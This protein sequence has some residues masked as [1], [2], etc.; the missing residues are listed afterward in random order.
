MMK[1]CLK[2][3]LSIFLAITALILSAIATFFIMTADVK[4]NPDKLLE[5]G[6]TI[7]VFDGDG[8]KIESSGYYS[9]NSS[10]NLSELNRQ[11]IR[12]FIA[13]EDK[14]FYTH[15]GINI[16]RMIKA[17]Y[18]NITAKAFKEGASTISQQ[19]IK[20]THLNN[21][22]TI[23]RKLKEIRLSLQLEKNYSKDEILEMYLNT[24]Y[25]GHNCYGLE[26]AA[27]FYYGIPAT[28]LNLEQ[29]ATIAGLLSSP[30]NYS[31]FKNPEACVKRRNIVLKAMQNC[32]F[33][34][35]STYV[36]TIKLPLSTKESDNYEYN[37]DYLTAVF[38]ELESCN[39]EPYGNFNE[40]KIETYCNADLQKACGELSSEYDD[41]II[42]RKKD[43]KV[44]AYRSDI[45]DAKRQIGSTAKPIF[46]YA[47]A[48]EEK[49]IGLFTKIKDEAV[50]YGGYK[51]ENYDKKYHGNVSVEESI[52][53]SYN[54]P[55]VKTLNALGVK[56]A[57]EYAKKLG[58]ELNESD[59]NLSLAL[60]GINS[61]MS[62]KRLCDSYAVFQNQGEFVESKFIKRITDNQG[63]TLYEN[64][65]K[66]AKTFSPS[67]CSLINEA[68]IN[69]AKIGTG[70]KLKNFDFDV[71]C[72][73]GT[74][75][76]TEGNTDA[77]ALAYTSDICVGVW[78]GDR[79]NAKTEVTGGGYC[80]TITE[81]IL[82][83]IYKSEKPLPLDTKTGTQE[84]EVDREE[85][86]NNDK[87]I[88]C[89][90]HCPKLNR[91]KL[92]CAS[93]NLPIERSTRFTSPTIPKPTITV[94]TNN[95]TIGLCQ[96]KYYSYLIKRRNNGNTDTIYNGIWK[97]EIY[98]VVEPGEY[99]YLITPYYSDE[100]NNFYGAEISLPKIFISAD[101]GGADI[102]DIAKK[103]WYNQ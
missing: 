85:Y 66:T 11:T 21:D 44:L 31:P 92:K 102:P 75:G 59:M 53:K 89:D 62:L 97:G 77:Y 60:G 68:L 69:T 61:G 100:G 83:K 32:N 27:Q 30:N 81:E 52:V 15:N 78:A 3:T 12:A 96:A 35:E 33:I 25:F 98:D 50:D 71:A 9:H 28:E 38:N 51:P 93:D 2:I 70:K 90:E 1:T 55:A 41:A 22:K 18:K 79:N 20:N 45:G 17:L 48:L 29:S 4:L 99:E 46:V 13:S 88:L 74:C 43:G 82:K 67:T 40:L 57:A 56:K 19:L 16:K 76:T 36:N 80:C 65:R 26:N 37:S 49:K 73:T 7:T 87:I 6:K 63:K 5:Q 8:N 54:I 23:S 58:V 14:Q 34:D 94:N 95:I 47:P 64:E 103:D 101:V 91:L 86:E 39:I 10:V 72:K 84:I 24:I 42:I